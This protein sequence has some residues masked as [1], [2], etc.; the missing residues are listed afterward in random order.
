MRKFLKMTIGR[1]N[2]KI[3][4]VEQPSTKTRTETE[5]QLEKLRASC[6]VDEKWYL[7][8][9]ED[10]KTA[11]ID[12]VEHYYFQGGLESRNPN[13]LFN[14]NEYL[15]NNPD[16]ASTGKNP[17]LHYLEFGESEGRS[18]SVYFDAVFYKTQITEKNSYS[19]LLAHY[20]H[21]GWKQYNPNQ[22]FDNRFY[23]ETYQDVADTNSD[24]LI[25][26]ISHG[27]REEREIHKIYS[28]NTYRE[29][30]NERLGEPTEPLSYFLRIGKK[31]GETLPKTSGHQTL[32]DKKLYRK[33]LELT[34]GPGEYF[35]EIFEGSEEIASIAKV[36][37]FAFYLPQFY[38]FKENDQ[39]WGAGF[40]EWRNVTR[41][42]PRFEGHIQPR[43][44]RDLGFYDLRNIETIREQ[45]QLAKKSG[46]KGFCFYYYWFNKTRLLD[47]PLDL[48]VKNASIDF[49]FTLMW[50]NENWTRRWDGLENDILMKQDYKEEDDPSLI[51]DLAKYFLDE[52]YEKIDDRPL[53]FIYRPGIIP[54]FKNR[55]KKWRQLFM[56]RHRINPLIM[57]AQGFG[58]TDPSLYGL[59]GAI[60]FPPHKLSNDLT[61][62][63]KTL[64]LHDSEFYGHYMRYDDLV[65]KSLGE[66]DPPFELIKTLVPSWD[67]EARKPARGMGFIDATPEKYECWLRSL[68]K[69][70][71]ERPIFGKQPYVFINAWNEWAE[72]ALLEPDL[73][74]GYAYL[75]ATFR[76]LTNNT[77]IH[78]PK[79]SI[80]VIGHDAYRHGA[81][82]LTLNI[83]KAMRSDF[84]ISP[85]LLLLEGGPLVSDYREWA[86]VIILNEQDLPRR[87]ILQN[88]ALN[89][90][91]R[92]ALSNTVVT[93]ELVRDL[94]DLGFNVVSLV[95]E[96]S[97]LIKEKGLESKAIDIA[98]YA[99]KT[100]FASAFVK[101][102]FFEITGFGEDRS[103]IRPQGI[104]QSISRETSLRNVLRERIG[105]NVN[106]K[107]VINVGY[108]DLRK[109]FDLF[110][111]IARL[112]INQHENCHFVW[113]G[114]IHPDLK[115]WLA[116][117]LKNEPLNGHL[118]ILPFDSDV[119]SYLNGADAYA[120]T[121]REDPFPSVVLEALCAGL[122]VVG[123]AGGGGYP[124]AIN[125]IPHGG[126]LVPMGDTTAMALV[127]TEWLHD[128][129][130]VGAHA[131]SSTAQTQYDWREYVFGLLELLMPSLKRVSVAIPNYNYARYLPERLA[132]IFSQ[133][134]PIYE[135]IFLDDNSS[136]ESLAV[137]INTANSHQRNLKWIVNSE[138]SRSVF[139]QW[140]KAANSASGNYLWIAEADDSA[141]PN[142]ITEILDNFDERTA[143]GF[144][145][146]K[147][148]GTN[149]EELA[150]SYDYYLKDLE[151][152]EKNLSFSMDG[153]LFAQSALCIKN[154]VLNVS[155]VIFN[156]HLLK[157]TIKKT[158]RELM[159]YKV[160]GDWYLYSDICIN[161]NSKV[162]YINRSLNLHRRHQVSVTH[163]LNNQRHLEE[164][165][166]VQQF[167]NSK[168]L[169]ENKSAEAA[170]KY[171]IDVTT[172]LNDIKPVKG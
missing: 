17:L 67:N 143:F 94:S 24:P 93:G 127:L 79:T 152:F 142:F 42:Q 80:L 68:A 43:L 9:Y 104:Y 40:T 119:N 30:L 49:Q 87:E 21:G 39:W 131:R 36:R 2:K 153:K 98:K 59:D 51:D 122:R 74:Y 31:A 123:F 113:L 25:H 145:D 89:T 27:W 160:A 72:G 58:D 120:L 4:T 141:E 62:V 129:D 164:I 77:K 154:P 111:Q 11:G 33:A 124:E 5:L 115:H 54:D 63:N 10:V 90:Q 150:S 85:T 19:T 23:L 32:S 166:K 169:V 107:I 144:C 1:V 108:G 118:H 99:S 88:I 91:T 135:I 14:S 155:A 82:L 121:S 61:P 116:I 75:N 8:S 114:E 57:M 140:E 136:D 29:E 106:A 92:T 73:H 60:E 100:V 16:V 151:T 38:P 46:L 13:Y 159:S 6:L 128:D 171:L 133:N 97:S 22:L 132:S 18:P 126:R 110:V 163:S 102:S 47:R 78:K 55:L 130:P 125:S 52:R 86:E 71:L 137:A 139:K 103:V 56:Q 162:L 65:G 84:G 76:A 3:K 149:G 147:Q 28:F 15:L 44:P 20:I 158:H 64:R 96:L 167:V 172:H 35:E 146:S 41:A 105:A 157:Q 66:K 48:F 170:K 12:P 53:F 70:A 156:R 50:A 7:S 26:Y 117:D 161:S 168:V 165:K 34:Q 81:Q 134:Y 69:R 83:L 95:H 112:V 45:V 109:G 138:N 148:I 101:N 37:A